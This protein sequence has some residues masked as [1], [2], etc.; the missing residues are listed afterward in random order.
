[1][2]RAH[3]TR[4]GSRLP[5]LPVSYTR[6]RGRGLS[7]GSL[8]S[9]LFDPVSTFSSSSIADSLAFELFFFYESLKNKKTP[10]NFFVSLKKKRE[11]AESATRGN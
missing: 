4:N 8:V 5:A 2:L 7:G 3:I 11:E 10:A 1:M 9:P 6:R